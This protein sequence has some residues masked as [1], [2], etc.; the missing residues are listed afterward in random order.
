MKKFIQKILLLLIIVTIIVQIPKWVLPP[1]WA[2][3]IY[4]SKLYYLEQ[5][6]RGYDTFF[7]GTSRVDSGISPRVF[8]KN[9]NNKT[10]SFNLGAPGSS[11]MEV[12]KL[13]KYVLDH[14]M[15]EVKNI[16]VELSMLNIH[17][18]TNRTS[19]RGRYYYGFDT[20]LFFMKKIFNDEDAVKNKL[21]TWSEHTGLLI[22]NTFSMG[23]FDDSFERWIHG[24]KRTRK[25]HNK[26]RGY[27]PLKNNSKSEEHQRRRKAFLKD[28]TIL[29]KREREAK[30]VFK[31][32]KHPKNELAI[33]QLENLIDLADER[34]INLYF[35]LYPKAAQYVYEEAVQTWSD[36][37]KAQTIN[38]ADPATYN[39]FYEEEFSFDRAHLNN[40]GANILTKACAT[41]FKKIQ[42]Q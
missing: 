33:E 9:T 28:K 24:V 41:A 23:I 38:L 5:E 25:N 19:A 6:E 20:Y 34:D 16:F 26:E 1:F 18:K 13:T 37:V 4:D 32:T 40:K 36:K 39:D 15:L 8:D 21:S 27:T 10:K 31:K 30:S 22:K 42:E 3:E 35:V 14:E 7:V 11:G 29:K 2:N 17:H 12:I